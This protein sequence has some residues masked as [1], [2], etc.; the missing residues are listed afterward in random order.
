MKPLILAISL[1]SICLF[2]TQI[3]QNDLVFYRDL[4]NQGQWWRI[5]SGNFIHSNYPHLLLNIAGLW[6]LGFLFIDHFKV[7]TFIFSIIFLGLSVGFG[8]YYLDID[9]QKYYGFSG[10]LY[11]LFVVGG[12]NALI[13]KDYFNGISIMTFIIGKIIW[14]FIYGGSL[15]SEE[16]IGIPVAI[17]AHMYG[18]VTACLIGMSLYAKSF[19]IADKD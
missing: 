6:I 3:F 8:L 11:G 5:F 18:V 1:L 9:L 10:I 17:N 12:M 16:L 14:D 19:F 4:I 15:S 13:E 7:R 2:I